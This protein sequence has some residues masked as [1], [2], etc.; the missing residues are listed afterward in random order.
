MFLHQR[1]Q[2]LEKLAQGGFGTTFLA[3]DTHLPSHRRCVV[4]QLKPEAPNQ[5]SYAIALDYFQKEAT[6]LEQLHHG[7]IPQLY[8]YFENEGQFYLVQE[9]IDGLTLGQKVIE[10]GPLP[11]DEVQQI[12]LRLLPVVSYLHS[13]NV[14]HR[15]IKPDNIILR[16]RDQ[17][18]VLIDFGSVKQTLRTLINASGEVTCSVVIGSGGFMPPEQAAQRVVYSSDLYSLGMTAVYLLTGKLPYSIEKEPRTGELL[19]HQYA[20]RVS[21]QLKAVLDKVIQINPGDRFTTASEMLQAIETSASLPPT[22]A[23]VM[24]T[25]QA[26]TLVNQVPNTAEQQLSPFSSVPTT[27]SQDI[28]NLY[29]QDINTF[30]QV[31]VQP[32]ASR[33][34]P[35]F[36]HLTPRTKLAAGLIAVLA[37][38]TVGLYGSAQLGRGR[39]ENVLTKSEIQQ[40]I[41]DQSILNM[42]EQLYSN[43]D[44][45]GAL[46]KLMDVPSDSQVALDAWQKLAQWSEVKLGKSMDN[47]LKPL[48]LKGHQRTLKTIGVSSIVEVDAKTQ[49]N[50]VKTRLGESDINTQTEQWPDYAQATPQERATNA[51]WDDPWRESYTIGPQTMTLR[52]IYG[53]KSK[54]VLQT[55]VVFDPSVD[56]ELMQVKLNHMLAGSTQDDLDVAREKL[57]LVHRGKTSP[58]FSPE[59]TTD[60]HKGWIME[61][62]QGQILI[63]VRK[64]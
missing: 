64:A 43:G 63:A 23:A 7:Q 46:T 48:N 26:P 20:P 41:R 16:A 8:A 39:D 27:Y 15:D 22:A 55:E 54:T 35:L 21:S 38:G 62:D 13:H 29:S 32:G 11:E 50:P 49:Q 19:W 37:V 60:R 53:C 52:F 33:K 31:P 47:E 14:I 44:L 3:E 51:S 56:F 30:D 9:W 17:I 6:L 28:N 58:S 61:T 1:F 5:K 36:S 34:V 40:V 25:A 4:K 45:E 24:T 2:V 12:L 57:K 42:A 18:P 10:N 59:F